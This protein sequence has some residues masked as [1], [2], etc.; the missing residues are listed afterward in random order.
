MFV[1]VCVCAFV[2]DISANVFK[3]K[4]NNNQT[5]KQRRNGGNDGL[6]TWKIPINLA[7]YKQA[8]LPITTATN[9]INNMNDDLTMACCGCCCIFAD[10]SVYSMPPLVEVDFIPN[11]LSRI[12]WILL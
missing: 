3:E 8:Y 7:N 9:T 6:W 11:C 2:R 4:K 10:L 5:N 12:L 1:C